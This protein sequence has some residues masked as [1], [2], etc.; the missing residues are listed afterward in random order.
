MIDDDLV[1][2]DNNL[3]RNAISLEDPQNEESDTGLKCDAIMRR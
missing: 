3:K 1:D 2:L